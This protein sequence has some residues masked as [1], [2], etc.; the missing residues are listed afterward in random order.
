MNDLCKNTTAIKKTKLSNKILHFKIWHLEMINW[1]CQLQS[2][3]CWLLLAQQ[4]CQS[5]SQ[6][7]QTSDEKSTFIMIKIDMNKLLKINYNHFI[8]FNHIMLWKILI[9]TTK[10]FIMLTWIRFKIIRISVLIKKNQ[11]NLNLILK[12][13]LLIILIF[14]IQKQEFVNFVNKIL[15]SAI[16]FISIF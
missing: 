3:L 10:I 2:N 14:L 11:N 7:I 4:L 16:C 5:C 8:L 6:F 12:I 13:I 15:H 9:L 1:F